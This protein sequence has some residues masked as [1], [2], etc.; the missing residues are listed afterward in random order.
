MMNA[1]KTKHP[2]P[3]VPNPHDR[4]S[5][6]TM[7]DIKIAADILRHYADPTI[8]NH[9][10]LDNLQPE[11]TEHFGKEL[12]DLTTDVAFTSHLSDKKGKS[13]VLIITE[14]KSTPQPFVL[15]QILAYLVLSWYKRWTDAGRPQSTKNFR[16]P[17]PVLVVLYNG[18]APW[19]EGLTIKDLVV[20]GPKELMK[21]IPGFEYSLILLNRFKI[22]NL[23]GA[24]E[25]QAV[26]ESMIRA[27]NGTFASGLENVIAHFRSTPLDDRIRELIEDIVRYCD[28]VEGVTPALVDKAI[29]NT[30]KGQEGLYMS[31]TINRGIQATAMEQGM[32]QGV[33]QGEAKTIVRFLTIRF[34]SVPKSIE[35][36]VLAITNVDRLDKLADKAALCQ[37]LDE[38][39]RDLE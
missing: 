2:I 30:I 11:P 3:F 8:S 9:I 24:P 7:G 13:E 32:E 19:D 16:L 12:Q 4:F 35:E 20:P 29:R 23:R 22:G 18:T 37:T 28:W 25:T 15:L 33:I 17:Q 21:F 36:K 10:D 38:F 26:I 5:R 6:K 34:Q 31:Q 39:A 27:T 1:M 14:H